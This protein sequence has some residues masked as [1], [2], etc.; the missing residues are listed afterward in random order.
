MLN[1]IV[2]DLMEYVDIEESMINENTQPAVDLQ[3]N[4]YDYICLVGKLEDDLGITIP[5]TDLRKITTLGDLD[6]YVRAK[7]L[8]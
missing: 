1:V 2:K 4:S 6:E 7:L 8:K 5:E 3:L